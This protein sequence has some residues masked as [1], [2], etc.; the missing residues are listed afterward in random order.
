MTAV[1]V[2]VMVPNISRFDKARFITAR[3]YAETG[4]YVKCLEILWDLQLKPQ[5][6]LF[7]R[8]MVNVLIA[9]VADPSKHSDLEK[10]T[11]EAIDLIAL[12]R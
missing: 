3:K 10:L 11:Q 8:A 12:I 4:E 2:I 1:T 7:R 6:S 5:L 9:L